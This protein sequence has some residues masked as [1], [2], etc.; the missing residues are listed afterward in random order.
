MTDSGM[1]GGCARRAMT[2]VV[3]ILATPPAGAADIVL[4]PSAGAGVTIS[5]SAGN[6]TRLRVADD[7]TFTL[8]GLAAASGALTGLC[9]D[10]ASG[11]VGTCSL[12]GIVNLVAGTGLTGGTITTSGTI[13]IANAGVGTAQ[14]SD[15][16][17][18][19]AKLAANGCTSGQVLQFNGAAWVCVTPV[20]SGGTVTSITPGTG[21]AGSTPITTTGTIQI[22]GPYQLPQTCTDGQVATSTGAGSNWTCAT[23]V[24][25]GGTVTGVTASA[26]LASIGGTAPNISLSGVVPVAN[27]GTGRS[28]LASNGVL[29]GQGSGAIATAVGTDGQLLAGTAGAPQWTSSPSI[30]GNLS[31][32]DSTAS[33]GNILKG[34]IRFLHNGGGP[35]NV[36]LGNGAG[37]YSPGN[38]NA[39]LGS[40]SLRS[41]DGGS[42]NTAVG[43][44]ALALL[45][46]GNFNVAVGINAGNANPTGSNN[47]YIGSTAGP[48]TAEDNTIRI[49]STQSRVFLAGINPTGFGTTVLATVEGQ[50]STL[51]SSA[52][53]KED[54]ADMGEGSAG[55]MALR[56]VTF[57]YKADTKP[58]RS[59]QYG[60]VAEEVAQVYPG[61][62]VYRE[63]GQPESVA[64]H[65][66][67]PMLLN[68][69]QRMQRTIEAQA[70]V[71]ASQSAR[72]ET[73]EAEL[74]SI[75][76]ALGATR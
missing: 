46:T 2:A 30:A 15:G 54:V 18:T 63:D 21:I 60:L 33:I 64:Y 71:V 62:V 43:N 73:V 70:A 23:P 67:A 8:P 52:R 10:I 41:L 48:V 53:Y 42:G 35:T 44:G 69:V 55:L 40:Q 16:A 4:T 14:I 31:L 49:G 76:R 45:T 6:A 1:N 19:A 3:A 25:S 37:S 47:V 22:A 59:L 57:T 36:Y 61:L 66:L 17:V 34:G 75:K 51:S 11:K 28:S 24:V 13:G 58:A 9:V 26:P 50:L 65:F 74:A 68:E 12:G 7:G 56:P 39:G 20:V 29:Y 5:N 38:G 32:P 27:G 72:L